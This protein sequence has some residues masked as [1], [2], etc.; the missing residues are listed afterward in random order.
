M[1]AV[2]KTG[3][4]QFKVSAGQKLRVPKIEGEAGSK[5]NFDHVLL[6]GGDSLKVGTPEVAGASVEATIK[7]Q[8]RNPKVTVFKYKRRKNYK[9]KK[10]HKQPM[11]VIEIS[12]IKGQFSFVTSKIHI[13][14]IQMAHK[15]AGGSTKNGRDSNAQR[16]GVKA[17]GGQQVTAGSII[18]RQVGSCFHAGE[19]VGKGKDF[20]LFAKVTGQVVFERLGK[21]KQRV[22]INPV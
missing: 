19:H 20:T 7:E 16:R 6:V 17:F 11:T 22:R 4:Q 8:V 15:K 14:G 5:I 3:G 12:S 9:R 2:F 13:R 10:G 21:K 1:Y 18:V